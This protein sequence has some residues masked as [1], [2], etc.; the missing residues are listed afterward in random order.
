MVEAYVKRNK[1]TETSTQTDD[2]YFSL[3]EKKTARMYYSQAYK[4]KVLSQ[5]FGTSKSFIITKH[6][7]SN[8]R[9]EFEKIENVFGDRRQ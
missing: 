4:E 7:W 8:F 2:L 5:N 1:F 3:T 6:M 9:K